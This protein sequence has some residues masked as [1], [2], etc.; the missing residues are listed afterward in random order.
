MHGSYL[1]VVSEESGDNG[2]FATIAYGQY[3]GL[4]LH[5][6]RIHTGE[7]L[8]LCCNKEWK[9]RSPTLSIAADDVRPSINLPAT[10][11]GHKQG[12]PAISMMVVD[13]VDQA[14]PRLSIIVQ[15][16]KNDLRIKFR[17]KSSCQVQR[18]VNVP[19]NMPQGG[20][21]GLQRCCEQVLEH[22]AC[23]LLGATWFGGIRS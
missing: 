3:E 13:A 22:T 1:K 6:R 5:V 20:G 10:V 15:A 11:Q 7:R 8:C 17:H 14:R 4:T 9:W 19:V 16:P 12:R 18:L 21:Y 2:L 23:D